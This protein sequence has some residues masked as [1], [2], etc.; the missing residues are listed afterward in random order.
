[1]GGTEGGDQGVLNCVGG[2][3]PVAQGPQCDGPEPVTVASYE[4]TESVRFTGYMASE[5][6]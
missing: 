3:L 4:L 2:F 1:M 5:E 6:V